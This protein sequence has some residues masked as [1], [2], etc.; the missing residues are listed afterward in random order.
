MIFWVE[1]LE[2]DLQGLRPQI[3]RQPDGTG[4]SEGHQDSQHSLGL[5]TEPTGEL[6]EGDSGSEGLARV[7]GDSE[8]TRDQDKQARNPPAQAGHSRAKNECR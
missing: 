4:H 7:E 8:E 6:Q 2:Q 1:I 3:F 5:C